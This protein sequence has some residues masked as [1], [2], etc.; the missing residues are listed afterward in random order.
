MIPPSHALVSSEEL[1]TKIRIFYE[2]L[3]LFL[4][5]HFKNVYKYLFAFVSNTT[6]W[7]LIEKLII[8]QLVKLDT[9]FRTKLF[10]IVFAKIRHCS[11]FLNQMNPTQTK[12]L[13][14]CF[15][16]FVYIPSFRTLLRSSCKILYSFRISP[17]RATYSHAT[18][19]PWLDYRNNVW[20]TIQI[21]KYLIMHSSPTPPFLPLRSKSSP[22][23]H[24]LRHTLFF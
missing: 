7:D 12:L 20:L 8:A 3:D 24:I 22:Q 18:H 17:M 10:V 11:F 5:L 15:P 9:W 19:F 1:I 14:L 21:M 23:H 13:Y 2:C 4:Y 16:I 6:Y